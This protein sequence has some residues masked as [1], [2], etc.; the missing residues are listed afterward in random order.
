MRLKLEL[1]KEQDWFVGL[2]DLVF[3]NDSFVL[4]MFYST[5]CISYVPSFSSS[6]QIYLHRYYLFYQHDLFLVLQRP[7][8]VLRATTYPPVSRDQCFSLTW[9]Y[10]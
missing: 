8:F 2:F 4:V 1:G 5:S 9:V 7:A 3:K 6:I 10:I